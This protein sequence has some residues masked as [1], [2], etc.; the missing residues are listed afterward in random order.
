MLNFTDGKIVSL[1]EQT[2]TPHSY[3]IHR[4]TSFTLTYVTESIVPKN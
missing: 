4:T 3:S 1:A 2:L